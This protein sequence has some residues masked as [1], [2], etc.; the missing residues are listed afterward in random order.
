MHAVGAIDG[1]HVVMYTPARAASAYYNYKATHSIVLMGVCDANYHFI[2][3]DIGD[4]GS[5][6]DGSI[7]NNS[8]IGYA[9]ENNLLG[10]PKDIRLK[11]SS[12]ILPFAFVADDAFRLKHHMMKPYSS[13]YLGTEKINFNYRLSCARRI[14][15]NT[16][17]IAANRF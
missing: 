15:E 14:I 13:S 3:V 6:S 9:I 10:I 12:R 5:Q 8:N 2:M 1:K 7:Y 11:N 17:G 4:T 16:F